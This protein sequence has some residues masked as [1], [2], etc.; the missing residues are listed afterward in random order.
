MF[1]SGLIEHYGDRVR[2]WHI[3]TAVYDE[4]NEFDFESSTKTSE[5]TY[6]L[7]RPG[8]GELEIYPTGWNV[9]L[10]VI[11]YF[12]S[13]ITLT[14][15]QGTEMDLIEVLNGDYSGNWYRVIAVR[16]EIPG[17]NKVFLQ[18]MRG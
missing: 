10:D 1:P 17:K 18:A 15:D 7:I 2:V 4:Y 14:A 11:A 13:T 8:T 5:E 16:S 12:P 9:H 3:S 6:A